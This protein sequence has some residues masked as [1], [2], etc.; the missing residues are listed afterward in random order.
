M[1]SPAPAERTAPPQPAATREMDATIYFARE[2]QTPL[3]LVVRIH[4][5]DWAVDRVWD[6][7]VAL[8]QAPVI[9]P[10]RSFN[11]VRLARPSL[12]GVTLTGPLATL[13]FAVDDRGW[14]LGGPGHVGAFVQQLVF[15]VTDEPGVGALALTMN[16]GVPAIIE[17][18]RFLRPLTRDSVFPPP[19]DPGTV[20]FARDLGLPLPVIVEGA[21]IGAT[22]AD[23]IRSRI[24]ALMR[25]PTPAVP[26]DTF[27]TLVT[28]RAVLVDVAIDGDL[29]VLDFAPTA[30]GWGLHGAAAL[31]AFVQQVVFTVT[32]EPGI[33]RVLLTERGGQAV[34]GGEGLVVDRPITRTELIEQ[35]YGS[36]E[37]ER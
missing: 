34:I 10:S 31:R 7:V 18:V 23:R 3:G 8:Q 27:N 25:G 15:T 17:G 29:A 22:P 20:W 12:R 36:D 37:K 4:M 6:R 14:G 2:R 5:D 35:A 21:G 13:D 19:P 33:A 11:V 1:V 28:L 26:E 30:D 32:E 24:E 9:G 16:D